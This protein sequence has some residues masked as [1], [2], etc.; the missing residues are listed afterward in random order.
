MVLK[1]RE[2]EEEEGT[3]LGGWVGGGPCGSQISRSG[4]T[5]RRNLWTASSLPPPPFYNG[6]G[7]VSCSSSP[8]FFHSSLISGRMDARR[9]SLPFSSPLS[10]SLSFGCASC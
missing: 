1:V 5:R 7:K 8:L 2:E 4:V 3:D 10:L 6:G 9:P